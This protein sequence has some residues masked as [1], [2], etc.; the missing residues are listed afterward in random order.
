M[1]TYVNRLLNVILSLNM[2]NCPLRFSLSIIFSVADQLGSGEMITF[3]SNVLLLWNL[4][5]GTQQHN[6][7]AAFKDPA[8]SQGA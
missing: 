2:A 8:M 5:P 4:Q 3:F 7:I 1:L 6:I